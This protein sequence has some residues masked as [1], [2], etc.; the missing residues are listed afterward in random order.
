MM[1]VLRSMLISALLAASPLTHAAGCTVNVTALN[2]GSY[3]PLSSASADSTGSVDVECPGQTVS[4]T[5]SVSSGSGSFS[6]RHMLAGGQSLSYNV[7]TDPL[8][9]VVWGD[10]TDATSLLSGSYPP[11]SGGSAAI[12]F[13]GRIPA[14]Q[15][16]V[17][18]GSGGNLYTDSLAVTVTY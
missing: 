6:A 12:T 14:K 11:V 9:S 1:H 15:N 13:Y 18:A 16:S 2:F 17:L 8:R 4:F 7:Y 5:V 3:N 10:G